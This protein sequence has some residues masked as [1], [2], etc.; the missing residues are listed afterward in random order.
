MIVMNAPAITETVPIVT[1]NDGVIRIAGTRVTLDTLV[2]AFQEGAT[3]E[4]IAQ[5]YPAVPLA[6]IYSLIG[7]YLRRRPEI[8]EYLVRRR[9]AAGRVRQENEA[10]F[11]PAG[12]RARLLARRA[13]GTV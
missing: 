3:A 6:D 13:G 4:E 2:D 5:Q 7:Y 1:D 9:Q 10:R 11:D 12:I 8:E